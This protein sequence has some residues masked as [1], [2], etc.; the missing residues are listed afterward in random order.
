M[1]NH[2]YGNL[3]QDGVQIIRR[4][5]TLYVRYDA[6][7]H[8]VQWREDSITD[9]EAARIIEDGRNS[10]DALLAIQRR[11]IANG[12]DPYVSNWNPPENQNCD[13]IN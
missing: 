11:L 10:A 2:V 5:G 13:T 12:I 6:G 1:D 4:D 9:E 7:S 8:F 3:G